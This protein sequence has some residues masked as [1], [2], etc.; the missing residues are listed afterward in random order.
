[1]VLK[2]CSNTLSMKS[3][4]VNLH[5]GKNALHVVKTLLLQRMLKWK[6][7][8]LGSL[9]TIDLEKIFWRGEK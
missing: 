8:R 1:M 9:F 2:S 7:T 4:Y 3:A 6:D 5:A